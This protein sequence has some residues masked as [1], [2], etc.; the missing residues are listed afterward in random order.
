MEWSE[1]TKGKG[2]GGESDEVAEQIRMKEVRET[3][4]IN[5]NIRKA[6]GKNKNGNGEDTARWSEGFSR[7][8]YVRVEGGRWCRRMKEVVGGRRKVVGGGR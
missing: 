8:V 3:K 7:K 6:V 2:G 1:E 4:G 5:K